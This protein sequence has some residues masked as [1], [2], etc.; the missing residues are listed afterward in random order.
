[1][2]LL[3]DELNHREVDERKYLR[4]SSTGD[5]LFFANFFFTH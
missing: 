4:I 1:M 3:K 2:C 5:N